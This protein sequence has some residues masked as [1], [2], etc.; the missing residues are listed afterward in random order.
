V[1]NTI[2]IKCFI[3]S[4]EMSSKYHM[5]FLGDRSDLK[6]LV[7][8]SPVAAA[9]ADDD[10][11]VLSGRITSMLCSLFK[12]TFALNSARLFWNLLCISENIL[13]SMSALKL[14]IVLLL[15]PLQLLISFEGTLM[16]LEPKLFVL[17][18]FYN[19]NSLQIIIK[20]LCS[21]L[22]YI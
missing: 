7:T 2:A 11:D 21:R 22:M 18:V 15:D 16:Y 3:S 17:I 12:F 5:I 1:E 19:C 14:K 8:V 13:C 6:L 20:I 4:S 9:A 10:H